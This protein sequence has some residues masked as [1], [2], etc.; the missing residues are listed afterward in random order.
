MA[1]KL[2]KRGRSKISRGDFPAGPVAKILPFQCRGV[3]GSIPGW[4]TKIPTCCA[5]QP[6]KQNKTKLEIRKLSL[7]EVTVCLGSHSY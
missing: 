6:K 4:G 1:E 7:R 3:M 5:V 2:G